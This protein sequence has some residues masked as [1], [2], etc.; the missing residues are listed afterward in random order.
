A[1]TVAEYVV[2]EAAAAA[3]AEARARNGQWPAA[4][5]DQQEA[6]LDHRV[7]LAADHARVLQV[8]ADTLQRGAVGRRLVQLFGHQ[9]RVVVQPQRVADRLLHVG[10]LVVDLGLDGG[11]AAGARGR[12]RLGDGQRQ[13]LRP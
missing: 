10:V 8:A 13:R 11:R 12:R 2:E 7:A 5:G 4:L 1:R 9:R 6:A 3:P